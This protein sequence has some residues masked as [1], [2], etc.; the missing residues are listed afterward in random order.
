M[1]DVAGHL[2]L[3][4]H[5]VGGKE[6]FS[7]GQRICVFMSFCSAFHSVS[8]RLILGD[9]EGH[10]ALD[11]RMYLLDLGRSTRMI[12]LISCSHWDLFVT[13]AA[14]AFPPESPHDCL[15]LMPQQ[16]VLMGLRS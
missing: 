6:L 7:A 9:V 11:K 8:D 5:K 15:H 12:V 13:S 1:Q 4:G 16:Q 3:C 2:H 10:L 14:R